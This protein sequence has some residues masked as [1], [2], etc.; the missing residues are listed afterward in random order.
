MSALRLQERASRARQSLK[1]F[2]PLAGLDELAAIVQELAA[3][4]DARDLAERDLLEDSDDRAAKG[5]A[6]ES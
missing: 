3:R 2:S 1:T 5:D 6:E 4:Q